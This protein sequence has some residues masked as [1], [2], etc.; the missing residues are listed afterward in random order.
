MK[1][2]RRKRANGEG[3]IGKNSKG[4]YE[5][6]ITSGYTPDGRQQFKVFT[7]KD[8]KV[9]VQ[10]LN[11]Y[12]ANKNKFSNVD[13]ISFQCGLINGIKVMLLKM[14]EFQQEQATKE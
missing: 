1:K 2:N 4:Y 14:L 9:V 5:A 10:K 13:N 12:K 3:Y 7:N 6:R 11:E 8:K